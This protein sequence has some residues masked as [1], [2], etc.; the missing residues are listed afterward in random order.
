MTDAFTPLPGLI[1]SR[2]WG[3][4]G[5]NTYALGVDIGG[6][7]LRAVLADMRGTHVVHRAADLRPG[8]NATMVLEDAVAMVQSLLAEE[9]MRPDHLVRIGVGFGGPVDAAQG[10]TRRSYRMQGWENLNVREHFEQAFDAMT[11]LENDAS[12]IAFGEHMFG[13]G[14]DVRD[15][16]YLHLSS[17][18]GSGMVLD[19]QLHRG[20]TTSAGEI[21]HARISGSSDREVENLLSISGLLSRASELGLATD[22]LEVLF[23]DGAAGQKTIGEAVGMLG[24]GLAGIVQLLDPA[25]LVLGGIVVRKGGD[26][27]CAAV[28]QQVNA[29]ISQTPPR[30]IPVVQSSLGY[31]AVA[32][33]GLAL[34]LHSLSQ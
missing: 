28:E 6:Y 29:L 33:G 2:E 25:M 14:R 30:R 7:G 27:F 23:A 22:D 16:F 8:S 24:V 26:P 10:I 3:L 32:I 31:D 21:G 11:L 9:Q 17:G 18:V 5:P 15:L 12:L 19:G 4:F 1:A 20:V 13:V 34:A